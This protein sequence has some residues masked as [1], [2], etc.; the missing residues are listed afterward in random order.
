VRRSGRNMNRKDRDRGSE[1]RLTERTRKLIHGMYN[2]HSATM[3][4]AD[5]LQQ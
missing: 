5:F 1:M 4:H 3:L 2:I